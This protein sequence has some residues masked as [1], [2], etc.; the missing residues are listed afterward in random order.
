[1]TDA[2]SPHNLDLNVGHARSWTAYFTAN[3]H[4]RPFYGNSLSPDQLQ[5]SINS[6]FGGGSSNGCQG[7]AQ[8]RDNIYT[9]TPLS[10]IA[11]LLCKRLHVCKKD[12]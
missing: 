11:D 9:Q 8:R 7:A 1:M 3:T 4:P 2:F 5:F 6:I 12:S 10:I